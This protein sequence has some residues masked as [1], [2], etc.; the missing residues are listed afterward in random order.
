MVDSLTG[1][2]RL[3]RWGVKA[4]QDINE[5]F[6]RFA[7]KFFQGS[8]AV[9]GHSGRADWLHCPDHDLTP[10]VDDRLDVR[11]AHGGR[12]ECAVAAGATATPP[13]AG[14]RLKRSKYGVPQRSR[15]EPLPPTLPGWRNFRG[16]GSFALDIERWALVTSHFGPAP[17]AAP[18]SPARTAPPS[19]RSAG[20][21]GC[22]VANPAPIA[23]APQRRP[24]LWGA[25]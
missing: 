11:A 24:W 12:G 21:T 8:M 16:C 4:T 10:A 6:V 19:S 5:R 13:G 9:L 1:H 2:V 23:R 7:T 15:Q 25:P 20:D 14:F 17:H 3:W 22:A 18:A